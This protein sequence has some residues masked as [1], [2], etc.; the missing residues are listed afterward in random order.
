MNQERVAAVGEPSGLSEVRIDLLVEQIDGFLLAC[1]DFALSV[2][3]YENA[4][5]EGWTGALLID[6]A[7]DP[8]TWKSELSAALGF[9]LGDIHIEPV[10]DA[11][12]VRATQD[13]FPPLS[14]GRFWVH[15][16]HVQ[17]PPPEGSLPLLVDAGIAFG[18]GEHGSTSGCLL[19]LD[20]LA[21][22]RP[23]RRV[24][25]M[26][27]GSAILAI[28]AVKCWPCRALAVDI[29]AAA[30]AAAHANVEANGAAG[31]VRCAVADGFA[32]VELRRPDRHDLIF[33]NILAGPLIDMAPALTRSLAPGGTAILSGLLDWQAQAVE[34]AYRATGLRLRQTHNVG[35][36]STLVLEKVRTHRPRARR[37]QNPFQVTRWDMPAV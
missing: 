37:S 35:D 24:L 16:S 23:L 34:G 36:W 7:P 29:D 27:C 10:I 32:G 13:K 1:E 3:V 20:A 30:V 8:V 26:G 19:A 33:A 12:W 18:T 4:D 5:S 25:D 9:E 15:G 28:A 2:S 22:R 11:D 14:V 21:R 31:R 6:K 17:E